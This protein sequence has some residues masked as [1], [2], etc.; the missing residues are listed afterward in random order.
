MTRD[1]EGLPVRRRV[2]PVSQSG[3][4][5]GRGRTQ[6]GGRLIMTVTRDDPGRHGGTGIMVSSS[7]GPAAAAARSAGGPTARGRRRAPRVP[8]V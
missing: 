4:G 1:S 2:T 8:R 3:T 6:A 5:R 7:H